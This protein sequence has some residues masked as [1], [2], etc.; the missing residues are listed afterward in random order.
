[1]GIAIVTVG[2]M[3]CRSTLL[4]IGSQDP[5]AHPSRLSSKDN[6]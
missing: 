2:G 6:R 5:V 4:E 3:C 1:M